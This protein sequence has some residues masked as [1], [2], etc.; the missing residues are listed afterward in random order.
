MCFAQ[1][2][3][4]FACQYLCADEQSDTE[5]ASL[6]YV[7]HHSGMTEKGARSYSRFDIDTDIN[8][9]TSQR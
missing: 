8:L 3:M 1:E 2:E 9:E 4:R 7:V 6:L 5:D